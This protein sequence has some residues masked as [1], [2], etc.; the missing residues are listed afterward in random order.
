MRGD[1]KIVNS[2]FYRR[3]REVPLFIF[4]TFY[5][6]ELL[7]FITKSTYY[8]KA[9]KCL[10]RRK[11]PTTPFQPYVS[12]QLFPSCHPFTVRLHELVSA[13]SLPIHFLSPPQSHFCPHDFPETALAKVSNYL[14]VHMSGVYHKYFN[15]LDLLQQ[16]T[17][18]PS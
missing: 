16:W 12:F 1:T 5:P 2:I 7:E 15:T 8:F 3:L 9:K 17:V 13:F 6:P 18:H 11:P 14:S 10:I 4:F